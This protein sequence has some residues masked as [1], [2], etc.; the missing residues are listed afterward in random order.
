LP[1]QE[2]EKKRL[3]FAHPA[4][5]S[6]I[7]KNWGL[8]EDI[9]MPIRYHHSTESVPEAYKIQTEMLLL[10][11]KLSSL[12]HG[13]KVMGKIQEIKDILQQSLQVMD[14]NVDGLIDAVAEK[15]IE[16]ISSFEIDPGN[17][18]PFSQII[19]EANE[20][21]CK[22]NLSN[23]HLM[24]EFKQAKEKAERL[25]IEL[26]EANDKLRELNTR[27]GLTGLYN[28]RFF[29]EALDQEIS[30]ALRYG[31]PIGLVLFDIDYFKKINHTYGHP[32][33]DLV[34][35]NLGK[36]VKRLVRA[37]DIAARYAAEEFAILMPETDIGGAMIQAERLRKALEGLEIDIDGS[38]IKISVSM[39]VT[40]F[41][42]AVKVAGREELIALADKALYVSKQS[43]RNKV[44][45]VQFTGS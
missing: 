34:L 11:N 4:L 7:L 39:G 24:M 33:G 38:K 23:V 42:E 26:K 29:Q 13:A 17:M 30:R 10:S 19:Q 44:T 6:E 18:K 8:P 32:S 45:A 41:K 27:D 3:G 16:I 22:L 14:H 5:S 36:E 9:Y 37:N 35:I 2:V 21:L 25:A 12:Y 28:H 43:R 31:R 40:G 1:I 15:S 20:E